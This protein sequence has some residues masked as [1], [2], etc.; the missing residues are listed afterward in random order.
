MH[1]GSP[2]RIYTIDAGRPFLLDL[3]RGLIERHPDPL[4]IAAAVVYLPSRRAARALG[5]AFLE[6]A[7]G[8]ATMLPRIRSLGEGDDDALADAEAPDP[9]PPLSPL[10]RRFALARMARAA[11]DVGFDATGLAGA[12]AGA[13][14]LARLL[15]SLYAEEVDPRRLADAAPPEFAAHWARAYGFVR[16][17]VELWPTYLEARGADDPA[18]A[19][20]AA[21]DRAARRLAEGPPRHPVVVAGSTGSAPAARRLMAAAARAPK[22]AVVLPGLDRTLATDPVGWSAIDDAHPQA[23]LKRFL[24]AE[25][26]DPTSIR[27]FTE[28]ETPP[29]GRLL[30]LALRPAEATENLRSRLAEAIGGA[31]GAPDALQ[32]LQLVEA[33]DEDREAAA[34]AVAFREIL[35]T[36][37]ETALLVTP[38]RRLARRVAAKMRRWGAALFDSGGE[39]L[40][41]APCGVFLRLLAEA[42]VAPDDASVALAVLRHPLAGIGLDA[43]DRERAVDAFDRACRGVAPTRAAGG[44]A[45]K[46]AEGGAPAQTA[47]A[48]LLV[49]EFFRVGTPRPF[50]DLL[51]PFVEAAERVADTCSEA[52]ADRLWRGADGALAAALL[53]ESLEAEE[54]PGDILPREFPSALTAILASASAPAAA[55]RTRIAVLGVLEARLQSADLVILSGLNEGVWPGE[56]GADPFLSRGMRRALG[57]P[58]PERGIGLA[59][60]DFGMLAAAPR[61]LLTR[62]ARQDGAP[63]TPS[64]WLVRLKNILRERTINSVDA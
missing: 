1:E 46:I 42:F 18:C 27:P 17:V 10:E 51:K 38:D 6:A 3:A 2:Q 56:V 9:V 14:S 41:D 26:A 62:A 43:A 32:G 45:A 54:S 11:R 61:V 22:G 28:A 53:A 7:G 31:D 13:D 52:G 12:L 39:P 49:P 40:S 33:A 63:T 16:L 21:L 15:D 5:D 55:Q 19:R 44:L 29:R 35:E 59:A 36:E 4:E 20:Y 57:L 37:R 23:G 58:S 24:S 50:L 25:G 64:R 47:H 30:S 34:I 48:A 60:H 8:R